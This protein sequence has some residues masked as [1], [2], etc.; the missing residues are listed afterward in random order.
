MSKTDDINEI[1]EIISQAPANITDEEIKE[2]YYNNNKDVVKT[3]ELLWNI[4]FEEKK[5]KRTVLDNV[6]ETCDAYDAEMYNFMNKNKNNSNS[7]S[8]NEL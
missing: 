1:N 8:N 7:N 3:L 4:S 2:I 6:R 5:K